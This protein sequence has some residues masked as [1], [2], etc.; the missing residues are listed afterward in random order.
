MSEQKITIGRII[1]FF[2]GKK[3]TLP[4]NMT[5]APAMVVQV[6]DNSV[7]LNVFTANP[8]GDPVIQAWSVSHKD[9]EFCIPDNGH[10]DW[11]SRV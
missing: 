11:P 7:N 8:N 3:I 1:E 2:P 10:W 6:F 9:S 4:N 5:S